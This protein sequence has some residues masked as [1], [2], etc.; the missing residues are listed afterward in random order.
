[1]NDK[2]Q[3]S[4]SITHLVKTVAKEVVEEHHKIHVRGHNA[5]LVKRICDLERVFNEPFLPDLE[6]FLSE[7]KSDLVEAGQPW[8]IK[9]DKA[10]AVEV[11]TVLAYLAKRH[12]RSVGSIRARIKQRDLIRG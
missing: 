12:S 10:L 8:M 11:K 6:N 7:L 9:E 2:R 4:T 3:A 1:M 5:G